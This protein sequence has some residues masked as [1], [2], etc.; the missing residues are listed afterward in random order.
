MRK[1]GVLIITYNLSIESLIAF[2]ADMESKIITLETLQ[3]E[4]TNIKLDDE[5][6]TPIKSIW[7]SRKRLDECFIFAY[8]QKQ[9]YNQS[10][11]QG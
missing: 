11:T 6:I 4:I 5:V 1:N 3:N 8:L 9:R 2:I 10:I 7:E